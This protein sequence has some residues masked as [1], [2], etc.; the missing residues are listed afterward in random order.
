MNQWSYV[1]VASSTIV[2]ALPWSFVVDEFGL[3]EPVEVVGQGVVVGVAAAVDG[4]VDACFGESF[5]VAN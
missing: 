1:R 4:A 2:G 5:G 3:V